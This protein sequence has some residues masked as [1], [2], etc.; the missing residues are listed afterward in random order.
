MNEQDGP[1]ARLEPALSRWIHYT[2]ARAAIFL[3]LFLT[4]PLLSGFAAPRLLDRP[5]S[6]TQ[7][8]SVGELR[9]RHTALQPPLLSARS[10]LLY[11]LDADRVLLSQNADTPHPPASLTKLMTALLVFEQEE[12]SRTVTIVAA[13]HVE[14]A[15]MGLRTGEQVSVEQLLWGLLV[16]SGNDAANALARAASG[17]VEAFVEQMNGRAAELGLA[18]THFANPH[19]LDADGH[20][21]SAADLLTITRLLYRYPRFREMVATYQI[22]VNSHELTNTNEL[23]AVFPGA[24]GIKTGT[25]TAAG[26]CLIAAIQRDGRQVILIVLGSRDRYADVRALN[27]YYRAGYDWLTPNANESALLNRLVSPSGD[28]WYLRPVG[29]IEP[30]LVRSWEMGQLRAFRRIRLPAPGLSWKTGM[31]VG[32]LEWRFGDELLGVQTLVLW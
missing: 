11:D 15:T 22:T 27:T 18:Q 9:A 32:V 13:D 4:T 21:S 25:S 29:A 7:A 6:P 16:P 10:Y 23:L 17:T 12:L 26:Q 14:G 24:V 30:R 1:P 8:V 20:L 19:G 28:R 2:R 31:E 3:L 5:Y